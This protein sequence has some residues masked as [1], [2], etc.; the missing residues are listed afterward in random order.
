MPF[1]GGFEARLGEDR[2]RRVRTVFDPVE[3]YG[4]AL[5]D[6]GHSV[7]I[8]R[9]DRRHD[10]TVV[11]SGEHGV[12]GGGGKMD[13]FEFFMREVLDRS[14]PGRGECSGRARRRL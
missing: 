1:V 14:L 7:G 5:A 4:I 9:D 13:A 11:A 2:K 12:F 8:A 6:L 3:F 10:L